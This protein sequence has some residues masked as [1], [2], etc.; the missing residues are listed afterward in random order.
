MYYL[1]SQGRTENINQIIFTCRVHNMANQSYHILY[2]YIIG[3]DLRKQPHD[4]ATP[5]LYS[6]RLMSL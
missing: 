1:K 4:G 2:T 5:L 6:T 3:I